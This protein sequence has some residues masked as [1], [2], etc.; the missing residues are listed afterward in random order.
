[1]EHTLKDKT[2]ALAGVY[3]CVALV[4]Q[5]ARKGSI[6]DVQLASALETLFRFDANS[7]LDVYGDLSSIKKGLSTLKD[8]LSG[9]H[10]TESMEITRYTINLLH[11]EKKLHKT[12]NM[13]DKLS[14]DLQRAQSKMDYFDVSHEN[15][16]ASLAEI[17][18]QNIS[19]LGAKIM[20]QG[21]EIYL[22][23]QNNANKIRS[24]LFAGIRSAVLWRQCGGGRL[25]LLFSRRKYIDCADQLLKSI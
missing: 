14:D 13:M 10:N 23:Q 25:Q 8:Q 21:E 1:M 9:E 19:P 15:I 12:Q 6:A 18:Q 16:I 2:L 24:L 11:L 5:L 3:R 17:Y 4:Q 7:V 22:S 20:V